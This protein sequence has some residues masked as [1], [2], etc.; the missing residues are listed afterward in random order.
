MVLVSNH[1]YPTHLS[2]VHWTANL[3]SWKV[4]SLKLMEYLLG[5][6]LLTVTLT[7]K[8]I[9]KISINLYFR[10]RNSHPKALDHRTGLA[11]VSFQRLRF[12]KLTAS[13]QLAPE[14][15]WQRETTFLFGKAYFSG[16]ILVL[17]RVNCSPSVFQPPI[18]L[19]SSSSLT[20]TSASLIA[21]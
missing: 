18:N 16:T 12:L 15:W 19:T 17:E 20:F 7:S 5:V 13:S 8:Y 11:T 4:F 6:A 3:F 21:T 1:L 2:M 10:K 14:K 9:S